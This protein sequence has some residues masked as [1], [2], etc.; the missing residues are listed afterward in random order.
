MLPLDVS[1]SRL[2][3]DVDEYWINTLM[4]A[5]EILPKKTEEQVTETNGAVSAIPGR[6][7]TPDKS[8]KTRAKRAV[9]QIFADAKPR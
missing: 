9:E 2:K 1:V 7:F 6:N 3:R 8:K 4:R 5:R